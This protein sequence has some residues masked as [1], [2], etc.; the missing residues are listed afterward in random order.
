MVMV[1]LP[2]PP[3][4]VAVTVYVA[5]A[6]IVVGVPVIA[7]VPVF[8]LKPAGKDGLTDQVT[9]GPPDFAGVQVLMATPVVKVFNDG[10]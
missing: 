7:P 1:V 4:F 3:A 10:V 9:T 6:V 2:L 8:K 5:V